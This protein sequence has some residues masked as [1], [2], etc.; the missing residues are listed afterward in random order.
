MSFYYFIKKYIKRK[1]KRITATVINLMP[2]GNR[3]AYLPASATVEASIVI[4]LYVYAVLAVAYVLQ[5]I[6]IKSTMQEA[7]YAD[8]REL[9]KYSYTSE[10]FE[11]TESDILSIVLAKKLLM[12]NLPND[13]ANISKIQGGESGI[14]LLGSKISTK[15]SELFLKVSY[16]VNNPFDIFGIGK[17]KIEQQCVSR[18]WLGEDKIKAADSK[19][20]TEEIVYITGTGS[21]YHKDRQCRYLNPSVHGILYEQ[22]SEQRNLSGGKYYP[23]ERC[24]RKQAA[25]TVYITEYGDRYH[26]DIEC[27]AL[28]RTVFEVPI[29]KVSD[30]RACSKCG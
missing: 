16:T 30:K 22:A 7:L 15:D 27:S 14:S 5:I 4:P 28:K 13:F 12:D 21:V 6:S 24:V 1:D 10:M 18:A 3:K 29:S 19:E 11:Q 17:V 20:Q 26:M 23:C 9:S 25:V 2:T 8:V